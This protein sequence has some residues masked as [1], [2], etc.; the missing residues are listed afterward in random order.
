MDYTRWKINTAVCPN[1]WLEPCMAMKRGISK[2]E[3]PRDNQRHIN[4]Y[5]EGEA[6]MYCTIDMERRKKL[7]T[8]LASSF[9]KNTHK[10]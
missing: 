10:V 1:V 3:G 4:E 9:T 8:K 7:I 5:F 6:G 2:C